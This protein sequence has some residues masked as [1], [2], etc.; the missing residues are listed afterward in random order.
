MAC[1]RRMEAFTEVCLVDR[2]VQKQI[3]SYFECGKK[4]IVFFRRFFSKSIDSCDHVT[5]FMG[6]DDTGSAHVIFTSVLDEQ[7][8]FRNTGKR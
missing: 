1:I 8:P 5:H 6:S 3:I 4:K 7:L 2:S